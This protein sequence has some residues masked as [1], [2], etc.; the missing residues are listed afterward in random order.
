MRPVQVDRAHT[1]EERRNRKWLTLVMDAKNEWTR[2]NF[3]LN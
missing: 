3:Y 1:E 2:Q